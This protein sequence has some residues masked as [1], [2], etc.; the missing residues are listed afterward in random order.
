MAPGKKAKK[1]K[2]ESKKL[3]KRKSL[4]VAPLDPK[5]IDTEW[6]DIFWHK[7]ASPSG[8]NINLAS[9]SCDKSV[10]Q[11]CDLDFVIGS[12]FVWGLEFL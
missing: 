9:A 7:N 12:D 8:S 11:F 3:K 6:W 1:S 10:W 2:K 5:T 4:P